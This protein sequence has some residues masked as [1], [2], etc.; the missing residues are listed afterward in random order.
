MVEMDRRGILEWNSSAAIARSQNQKF[1]SLSA[2]HANAGGRVTITPATV[3]PSCSLTWPSWG[4]SRRRERKEPTPNLQNRQKSR[5][6]LGWRSFSSG[7]S[8]VHPEGFLSSRPPWSQR[9]LLT[10][11]IAPLR[12]PFRAQAP[13]MFACFV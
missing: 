10:G 12:L 2:M 5:N 9:A 11:L 3:S 7:P 8:S 6:S 1:T 4:T 13:L